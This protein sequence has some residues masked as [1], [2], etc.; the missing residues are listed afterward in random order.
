MRS[1]LILILFFLLLVRGWGQSVFNCTSFSSTGTCGVGIN[2]N[3][4]TFRANQSGTSAPSISGS[5][6]LLNPTGATHNVTT[7]F[8]TPSQ[9]DVRSFVAT[10]TFIPNG[11]NLAFVLQ[12]TTNQAGF[13]GTSFVAGAGC[14]AG[15]FQYANVGVGG[16]SPNNVFAL[17]LDSYSPLTNGGSFSY[18]SAQW[19]RG[20]ATEGNAQQNPCIPVGGSGTDPV[21]TK[22]STSPVALNS[23]ANTQDTTTGDVYSATISYDGSNLNLCLYDVTAANGNCVSGTSGTGT[24][25]QNTWTGIS[26]PTFVGSNTAYVG[27]T[28]ATGVASSFPLLINSMSYTIPPPAQLWSSVL[29]ASRAYDWQ[30]NAGISG[31][32][33]N[34][35][36]S[37]S[38]GQCPTQSPIAAYTGSP[39]TIISA[40][41]A[42]NNGNCWV[43]LGNGNFS[44]SGPIH[45]SGISGVEL[46]GGGPNLTHLTFTGTGNCAGGNGACLVDF[47]SS[48]T[49]DASTSTFHNWT[50]GFQQGATQVTLDSVSGMSVGQIL[51]L[52]QCDDGLSGSTTGRACTGNATD[53]TN[54]F[55]CQTAYSGSS[56]TWS[57]QGCSENGPNFGS[58]P[59][60]GQEEMAK[61]TAING[62]TVTIEHPLIHPN[63]RSS[64]NPQVWWFSPAS[65]VGFRGFSIDASNFCYPGSCNPGLQFPIAF[66]NVYNYWAYQT[67]VTNAA[68]TSIFVR[69][70]VNGVIESNYIYNITNSNPGNDSSGILFAGFHTLIDNNIIQKGKV[71]WIPFLAAAGNVIAYNYTINANTGNGYNFG[72]IWMN[73]SNGAD[74]NLYEGNYTNQFLWDQTHG[75]AL[76][77]TLYRNFASGWE[78]CSNGPCGTDTAKNAQLTPIQD[79]STGRYSNFINNVLGTATINT[80]GYNFTNITY[81]FGGTQGYIY[82]IAS[83]NQQLGPGRNNFPADPYL[84]AT[85]YRWG[86]W[87]VFNNSTQCNTSEVPSGI[88]VLPNPVPGT[89]PGSGSLPA[90]FYYTGRPTWWASAIP[91][92]LIG[93]DIS[94]G[95]VGACG[96][97]FNQSGQFAGV[98]AFNS[99]QCA[100]QGLNSAWANHVNANSAMTCYLNS[101]GNPDGTSGVITFNPSSC[102]VGGPPQAVTPSFSPTPGSY[103]S[104]S[105]TLS[106][107]TVGG[108]I[109]Y[110]TDGTN[111]SASM[112]GMC[113]SGSITY[114]SAI[115]ISATTTILAL[116]T[117]S[118]FTN[119]SISSG[120]YTITTPTLTAPTFLP[121]GNRFFLGS[122]PNITITSSSGST[123]C[124]TTDGST[125]AASTPGTC[126][127]GTTYSGP[128]TVTNGQQLQALA[129]QASFANSSITSSTYNIRNII[130]D[131]IGTPV[132]PGGSGLNPIQCSVTPNG[133]PDGEGIIFFVGYG[134]AISL[135]NVTDNVNSGNYKTA[136][137]MH[138]NGSV[139]FQ[140][141]VFYIPSALP[142]PTTIS[143]NLAGTVAHA[144]SACFAVRAA[145]GTMQLD[146]PATQVGDG[147]IPIANPTSGSAVSPTN[148]NSTIFSFL[149][150]NTQIPTS[151]G[152]GYI[153]LTSFTSPNFFTQYTS[154][155]TVT[156]T[157]APWTM[158][159]DQWSDLQVTMF[160]SAL[161]APA[162]PTISGTLKLQGTVKLIP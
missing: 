2:A 44:L 130:V 100:G 140:G 158:A 13:Q 157:N 82:N 84:I 96:G 116:T 103:T 152:T 91:F 86:N 46:R 75:T 106:T 114:S 108:V 92:P 129:T 20:F 156:A 32:N 80:L 127:H 10:F 73:H 55:N 72:N 31:G 52:D 109:C 67:E 142:L 120:T 11:Q 117:A 17:E 49:T 138:N 123:I 12:N 64:Q 48:D 153:S 136:I 148:N 135:N 97:T 132:N 28:N 70:G 68:D 18:S 113:D 19:Y 88:S 71:A 146:I 54:Y 83:G 38:W 26:I 93:A 53:T 145:T 99:S 21:T 81:G 102:Y 119:S 155:T 89:C 50:G 63:W 107:S 6:L 147:T 35:L 149:F 9:V 51:V 43:L 121:D 151:P 133:G 134:A 112:A 36:P 77:N 39:S 37:S 16:Q 131:A 66:N 98:A 74:Y 154:Q 115:P 7:V 30:H 150:T 42:N 41:S 85:T 144:I 58:L 124:Y 8:Y 161:S 25:Y 59:L 62:T 137:P 160:F 76:V 159:A 14:E 24:F 5:Q 126:S 111:P 40:L 60:R 57:G 56:T 78:S 141:G 23:P 101:G 118:G 87:D 45:N 27:L 90:S 162:P 34:T 128:V 104:V 110:R 29:A 69:S 65:N 15:F 47:S 105:V 125:P 95:N 33:Q 122:I 61:I 139:G 3:G 79:L 1:K 143:A 22:L 4:Q 94:G